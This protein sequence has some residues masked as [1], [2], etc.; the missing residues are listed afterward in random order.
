M[1]P[2]IVNSFWTYQVW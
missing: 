1:L 2:S